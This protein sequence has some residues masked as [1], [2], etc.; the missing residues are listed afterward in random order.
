MARDSPSICNR[1]VSPVSGY[2]KS[3]SLWHGTNHATAAITAI[4]PPHKQTKKE[5]KKK[6]AKAKTK[7]Q[8]QQKCDSHC[9]LAKDGKWR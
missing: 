4:V 9:V 2:A 5:N 3:D 7:Q 8:Q 1:F 6:M